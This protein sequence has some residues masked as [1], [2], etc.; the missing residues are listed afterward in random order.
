MVCNAV[1][2]QE[3]SVGNEVEDV[4]PKHVSLSQGSEDPSVAVR[5][6]SYR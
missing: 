3:S 5:L 2:V 1:K 6:P 4:A